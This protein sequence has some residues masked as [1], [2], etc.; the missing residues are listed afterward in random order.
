VSTL[1]TDCHYFRNLGF[2]FPPTSPQTRDTSMMIKLRCTNPE[3]Y[4]SFCTY[5]TLPLTLSTFISF[6]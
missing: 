4:S 3:H 2:S 1:M 5:V 6:E